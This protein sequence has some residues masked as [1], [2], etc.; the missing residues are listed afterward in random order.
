MTPS[1]T[2]FLLWLSAF[3]YALVVGIVLQKLILPMMPSMHAGNGLMPDDATYFHGVAV[4]MAEQIRL[5]GWSAWRLIPSGSATG[6][7]GLLAAVYAVLGP[8]PVWFLPI[9][10]AMHALG[11]VLVF[12]IALQILPSRSGLRGGLIAAF[13][14]L[15]FPSALVWYGQ[16]H[17]DSF[18][19]AGFLLCL[20]TFLRSFNPLGWRWV[21]INTLM[22]LVGLALVAIM[23]AHLVLIFLVAFAGAFALACSFYFFSRNKKA[24]LLGLVT[25]GGVLLIGVATLPLVPTGNE[26]VANGAVE[27]SSVRNESADNGSVENVRPR[28]HWNASDSLPH[29]LDRT[30]EKV[31]SIRAHFV[32]YGL[33]IE[34]GSVIDAAETPESMGAV[35]SYLPRAFQIGVLAPFPDFWMKRLSLPRVIGA[36]ETLVFY[37]FI[38]GALYLL[39]WKL[40]RPAMLCLVVAGIILM[41]HAY[42]SPNLGTLHRVRYGQWLVLLMLGSCGWMSWLD[43]LSRRSKSRRGGGGACAHK[44]TL[45]SGVRA[46][47]TGLMVMLATLLGFLGLLIR[48]LMLINK[49][50]F[51]E[52]LDSYYLAMMPPMFFIT[53]FSAPLGDLLST[54]ITQIVER[55]EIDTLLRAVSSFTLLLFAVISAL[56][57]IFEESIFSVFTAHSQVGQV[58][59][60]FPIALLLLLFSGAMVVGNSL[61]NSYGRP[62]LAAGAQLVVPLVVIGSILFAGENDNVVMYAMIGMALGQLTNLLLLSFFLHR[63]RFNVIPGSLQPLRQEGQMLHN[64]KWLSL[65]AL[66]TGLAV[67]V[68]YWFAG[69]I[70]VGVVSTWALGSKLVQVSSMLG[71]AL[72]A[73]VFVPYIS[74]VIAQAGRERIRND[75]FASLVIGAWGCA[76]VIAAVFVFAEPIVFAATGGTKDEVASMHLVAIIKLGALQLPFALSSILLFKLCAVSAVSRKAVMSALIGF[77]VN[78]AL[79]FLFVPWLGLVGLAVAWTLASLAVSLVVIAVTRPQSHLSNL[80]VLLIVATW[81]V[82]LVFSAAI[83]FLS[84]TAA[85]LALVLGGGLVAIQFR[86]FS[87]DGLASI[88]NSKAAGV[89]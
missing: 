15:I 70:G 20:L 43:N 40:N 33:S 41:V 37:L 71:T 89:V 23:R 30:F 36:F 84:A 11:A 44:T 87:K 53:L 65:C 48:D 59:V 62:M 3:C 29:A 2:A 74:K 82:L 50:G 22:F 76:V 39:C 68:N 19:I 5:H 67:P 72:M 69:N 35:I 6:N 24:D 83:H 8:E 63:Y 1:R 57:L 73:A 38:P 28:W 7:V 14:F 26:F 79:N 46:A 55:E 32:E 4:E 34:A 10:A 51:G 52:Q 56:L 42:V 66:L 47:G 77:L 85:L 58:V 27:V 17:K 45:P 49:I 16:N 78:V 86:A 21:L 61:L 60:L 31:S 81:V 18:V 12:L 80:D 54:R 25:A 88:N 64:F 9:N 75:L 13:C